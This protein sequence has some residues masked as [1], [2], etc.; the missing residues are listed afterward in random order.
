[1]PKGLQKTSW[2]LYGFAAFF[3]S[4]FGYIYYTYETSRSEIM[5][6]ID[7]KLFNAA[8]SVRHILGDDYHNIVNAGLP[9]SAS[10][11]K[12]KSRALSEYAK[13]MQLAYVYAMV[14]RDD[15][16]Y[17][18]ASSY[19][20]KDQNNGRVTQFL[21]A[22]PEATELN[23]EAFFSTEPVFEI[24]K[25]QWGYFKSI[26]VTFVDNNG[27]TYI[28][29]ADITISDLNQQL[30]QSVSRAMITG[31]FF[32]FI[33]ALIA[34]LYFLQLKRSL[35]TDARTGFANHVALEY[36]IK[37]TT[38]HRME[39]AVI[40]INE[41]ED[42]S[43]FYGSEV[44]DKVM[45]N[46]LGYFQLRIPS[47][48]VVYRLATNKIALL[49]THSDERNID[50]VINAF[51]YA[52]PAL[53]EP[54]IYVS[55]YAGIATGNKSMLI[56][57][58]H[59][60]LQQAKLNNQ[61]I[62][63]YENIFKQV[64]EQ[65]RNNVTLAKEVKE[66]FD[67]NRIVPYFQ[68]VYDSQRKHI[69]HYQCLARM[70]SATGRIHTPDYFMMVL[71][72][73]RMDGLLR[74]TMFTRC[75]EQ[76]RKT[77]VCWSINITAQDIL[78]P[79]LSEFLELQLRRY[80]QPHNIIFQFYERDAIAYFS[81]VK[82]FINILKNKGAQVI[83]NEFGTGFSS[84]PHIRK[85]EIDGLKLDKGLVSQIH[86][87]TDNYLFIENLVKYAQ[88]LKLDVIAEQVDNEQIAQALARAGVTLMQGSH[89]APPTPYIH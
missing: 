47:E 53:K 82:T 26:F 88:Q 24:S 19:T 85:L 29:G 67:N 81:E 62:V 66:A 38:K 73:S 64:E 75:I 51:N 55:L 15:K 31:C 34:G 60:A 41:L 54:Y 35:S 5:A 45:A 87:N 77:N 84:L 61:R 43:S 56:E 44:S 1:M 32:F 76:F 69:N 89:F 63:R 12:E 58:A 17:F 50:D 49:Q 40:V 68:A 83:I 10:M 20:Q 74:R 3:I 52:I 72:R 46:L 8:V 21:D 33:A 7:S 25:D 14:L 80:P 48:G 42:I 6:N 16:V 39:L 86:T 9:I 70:A 78:D 18:S 30:Q 59:V 27:H 13:Q 57:N 23:K 11:Y 79:S 37:R 2:L 65:F 28:T 71:K 36:Y 4:L 22:Y